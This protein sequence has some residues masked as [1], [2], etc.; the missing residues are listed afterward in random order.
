MKGDLTWLAAVTFA[1]MGLG[2]HSGDAE[3]WPHFLG[4]K[5]DF[6]SAETDLNLEFDV[7]GP[8]ILWEIERGRGH[9]G[10]VILGERLVLIHQ[11]DQEE[12][13]LCLDASN[14]STIWNHRYPVE[15]SQSYG[16]VDTPRSSPTID[17]ETGLVYTLGNDGDLI[18]LD[19]E[20]GSVVWEL[21]L[22]TRFGPA[23]FFFGYGS[24]PLIYKEQLIIQ[25]GSDSAT[26]AALNKSNGEM[27]WTVDHQWN[28]SY[29]SPVIGE[30]NGEDRLFV[31]AG[32]MVDPPHGGL[33]C[34]NPTDGVL[35]SAF[36]WRSENFASVN[37][38]TPV[39]CGPNRVFISEDY[40]L[41]GVMLEYDANFRPR[42]KWTSPEFGC[43]F[44]TPIYHEG[45]LYGFGGNGGL[46]LG[47]DAAT[48]GILW[49]ESFYQTTIPWSGREIPISMGHAHLLHVE[50]QFICLSENGALLTMDLGSWGY[51]VRSKARLFYAPE[52]W[53]PPALS[54][55][56]LYINQNEMGSR[57]ICYDLR[58]S[59]T[60]KSDPTQP[61]EAPVPVR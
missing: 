30:I 38:A 44:Q 7:D 55:G 53:A 9:S 36:R 45:M 5:L 33:L 18:C 43:Q 46:M 13:V 23:P 19:I 24:S 10:P 25:A 31:F 27:I 26:V 8:P 17:P 15:V 61:S 21:E 6:H 14:G 37:A 2:L 49:N 60:E 3:D 1:W 40:G 50:D 35:D 29:A 12:E 41:G 56:R 11:F 20:S 59:H 57:L 58:S 51:R 54:H 22:E 47:V 52:A 32:G 28:G 48:G 42:I 4:P 39:P 34:I 16:I